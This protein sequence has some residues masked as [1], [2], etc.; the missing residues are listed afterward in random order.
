MERPVYPFAAVIGQED[1]RLGLMLVAVNPRIGGLLAR[2]EKGTAK[3]TLARGLAALLP[4]IT[5]TPGCPFCCAPEERGECP[6]CGGEPSPPTP[7]QEQARG[8]VGHI[9]FKNRP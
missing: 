5:V 9:L 6:H 7:S 3:S 2:G 8:N 4:E 1:L